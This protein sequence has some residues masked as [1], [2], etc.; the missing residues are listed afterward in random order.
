MLSV[1]GFNLTLRS[2]CSQHLVGQIWLA[3]PTLGTRGLD[4]SV[5]LLLKCCFMFS[6]C[7]LCRAAL[8]GGQR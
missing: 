3:G 1:T 8:P 4:V 5:L 7:I 6:L 2:V